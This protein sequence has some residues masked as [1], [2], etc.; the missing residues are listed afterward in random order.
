[1]MVPEITETKFEVADS[2]SEVSAILTR[3][4]AA[5]AMLVFGHGAGTPIRH[6]LMVS[7]ARALAELPVAT[8]R[9]NYPYSER[10]GAADWQH[11][12]DSLDVLLSTVRSAVAYAASAAPD[13]PLF[14]GGRSLSSQVT[15]LVLAENAPLD[16]Q[17]AVFFVYPTLW[18][19]LL[20][21][22]VAH[23][24][25]VS[26]P[27]LFVQGDRDHYTDL[28]DLRSV[29]GPIGRRATLRVVSGADHFYNLPEDSGKNQEEGVSEAAQ[30]VGDWLD[31]LQEPPRPADSRPIS[32]LP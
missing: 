31:S 21:D 17:G 23:L 25:K 22:P 14:V 7:M 19:T 3:P 26:R 2:G 29:L 16:V 28:D 11:S 4:M 8:F 13:L 24:R 15:S 30:A 5:R 10:G 20:D 27:M 9:F 12:L 1:M 6:R 32:R 18:R